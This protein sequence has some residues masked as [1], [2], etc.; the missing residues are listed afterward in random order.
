M[1]R[2]RNHVGITRC[3]LIAFRVFLPR[4]TL[5]STSRECSKQNAIQ[6]PLVSRRGALEGDCSNQDEGTVRIFKGDVQNVRVIR[7]IDPIRTI[8]NKFRQLTHRVIL[9]R[10][11]HLA[12]PASLVCTVTKPRQVSQPPRFRAVVFIDCDRPLHECFSPMPDDAHHVDPCLAFADG[13]P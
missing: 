1:D 6:L 5:A 4:S 2:T 7:G 3:G 12:R 11:I 9:D 10:A 13:C 8:R